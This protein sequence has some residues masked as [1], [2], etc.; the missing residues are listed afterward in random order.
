M[1]SPSAGARISPRL[2]RSELTGHDGSFDLA[3]LPAGN[4]VV[5]PGESPNGFPRSINRRK[6]HSVFLPRRLICSRDLE[7]IELRAVPS[8]SVHLRCFDGQGEPHAGRGMSF[9][10]VCGLIDQVKWAELACPDLTGELAIIAPR[11]MAHTFLLIGACDVDTSQR[12]QVGQEAPLTNQSWLDLGTLGSDIKDIRVVLYRAPVLIV[13]VCDESGRPVTTLEVNAI[14]DIGRSPKI[15][16]TLGLSIR[17]WRLGKTWCDSHENW[18]FEEIQFYPTE[19]GRWHSVSILPDEKF[20]LTV[21]ANN[22]ATQ[23]RTLQLEE[24]TLTELKVVLQ[25]T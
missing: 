4:Y 24:G 14:Y 19:V 8:V 2:Y 6:L 20:T 5:R 1:G 22:Y 21:V 9:V 12:L 13:G 23:V 15:P 7:T 10:V 3:P 16:D 17:S 11:N 18:R 25:K